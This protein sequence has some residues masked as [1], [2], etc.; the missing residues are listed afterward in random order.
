MSSRMGTTGKLLGWSTST[1]TFYFNFHFHGPRAQANSTVLSTRV[2][3]TARE[4]SAGIRY[5]GQIKLHLTV[6][7]SHQFDG[8]QADCNPSFELHAWV[9]E[10]QS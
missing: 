10:L 6:G 5:V 1:N 2:S 8:R 4:D 7:D 3:L 9:F